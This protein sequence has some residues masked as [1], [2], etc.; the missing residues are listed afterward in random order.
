MFKGNEIFTLVQHTAIS[1]A[2]MPDWQDANGN[3]FAQDMEIWKQA[4]D[5]AVDKG[6]ITVPSDPAEY[7]T[8]EYLPQN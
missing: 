1:S 4:Q 8:N 3:F 5:W 6:L 2:T 7:F